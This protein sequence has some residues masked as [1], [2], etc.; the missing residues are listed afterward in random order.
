MAILYEVQDAP[1]EGF[2]ECYFVFVIICHNSV[3]KPFCVPLSTQFS[4]ILSHVIISKTA[5]DSGI[6]IDPTH[7]FIDMFEY[8]M[9][10][11]AVASG[12]YNDQHD[13]IP[14]QI[15]ERG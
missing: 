14:T 3:N 9:H 10:Q 8:M 11:T 5:A 2:R 15:Y 4:D 6:F 7:L 13:K 12:D 1:G